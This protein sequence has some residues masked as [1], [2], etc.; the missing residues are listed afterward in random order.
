MTQSGDAGAGDRVLLQPLGAERHGEIVGV[1]E[2]RRD[3]WVGVLERRGR[4]HLV[5]PWRD[6]AAAGGVG[7][8]RASSAARGPATSS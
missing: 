8:L 3:A 5:T 1:L 7:R 6:T 2:G 4:I